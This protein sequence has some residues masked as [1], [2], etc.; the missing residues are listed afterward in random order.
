MNNKPPNTVSKDGS[1]EIRKF[2]RA[3]CG[4]SVQWV[5]VLFAVAIDGPLFVT[6]KGGRFRGTYKRDLPAGYVPYM[7]DP[8]CISEAPSL[9]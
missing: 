1:R 7:L 6:L 3:E 8:V 2:T 9:K 5:P 4:N